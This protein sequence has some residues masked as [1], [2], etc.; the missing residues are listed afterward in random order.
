MRKIGKCLA[1]SLVALWL[2][3]GLA[4]P[5]AAENTL[6]VG[7][8]K[9]VDLGSNTPVELIFT[10]PV[11]GTYYFHCSADAP[12]KAN[13]Q[14]ATKESGSY[15]VSFL[16]WKKPE[17]APTYTLELI[18]EEPSIVTVK[19]VKTSGTTVPSETDPSASGSETT[20]TA[21]EPTNPSAS[22]STTVT[23][24]APSAST[25]AST[26]T[27]VSTTTT[28]VTT[29]S[30]YVPTSGS[31]ATRSMPTIPQATTSVSR[32]PYPTR[33]SATAISSPIG[34]ILPNGPRPSGGFAD[35]ADRSDR[36]SRDSRD[37]ES[38][39]V[40]KVVLY[41]ILALAIMVGGGVAV[42]FI[43]RPNDP[44]QH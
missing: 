24:A 7:E 12:F 17:E 18:S 14:V 29:T 3:S 38:I 5:V 39:Q 42:Y 9:S 22:Q 4:V 28:T 19:V 15:V 27:T 30:S 2:M 37:D 8:D 6:V 13:N 32:F 10:A 11:E 41:S 44:K 40:G 33:S 35:L 21:S 43:S 23:T 25:A 16:Y 26:T 20:P 1:L 31:S 34:G 36:D